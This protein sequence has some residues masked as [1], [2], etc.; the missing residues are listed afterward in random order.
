MLCKCPDLS[1]R[2]Q[3]PLPPDGRY[4]AEAAS[5]SAAHTLPADHPSTRSGVPVPRHSVRA[6]DAL[7]TARDDSGISRG[8][9]QFE[10]TPSSSVRSKS[11]VVVMVGGVGT[12]DL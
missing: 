3:P 11:L 7:G 1:S 5:S 8:G 9:L 12:I 2:P 4:G 10:D 6:R